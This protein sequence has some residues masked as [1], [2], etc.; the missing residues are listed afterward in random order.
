M[1]PAAHVP[2][3]ERRRRFTGG[4]EAPRSGAAVAQSAAVPLPPP[5]VARSALRSSDV[6]P[7]LTD[8]KIVDL[9]TIVLGP[10]AT[11]TLADLGAQVIKVEP[12][13][14][15]LY[16]AAPPSRHAGMGAPFLAIN[17]GKR[18]ICLDLTSEAGR[19]VLGR[20]ADSADVVIHNML[21]RV[22]EKL[23][24][25]GD[26]LRERRPRLIHCVTPGFGSEGPERD[27]PAYD[28][29]I[30]GRMGLASLMADAGGSPRLVPT[31]LAD[32][33][34]G[35][36]AAIAVLAALHHREV[37]GRGT[38][39]EVP[40][41]E[42]MTGFLLAEHMGGRAFEPELGPA[43]YNRL[44]NPHRRPHAT[45]DG[46]IVLLPYSARHWQSLL[47]L[48][49]DPEW[50]DADWVLDPEQRSRRIEELYALVGRIMPTRSTGE[51]LEI[52]TDRG[53]PAGPVTGLDDLFDDPHL[54]A[55]GFFR[56]VE[57]PSEGS[58]VETRPAIRVGDLPEHPGQPVPRLGEHGRTVLSELGYSEGETIELVAGGAVWIP[59]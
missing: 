26:T 23:G 27:S 51:W 54:R 38:S 29:V 44:L 55:V 33:V 30:Q 28:D 10:Y 16:R 52:L 22:A 57:H 2:L 35:L 41:L 5:S 4:G 37:T 56:Q 17:R 49:D 40:M 15:D 36:H 58:I 45:S 46:H 1:P 11:V 7:L 24:V 20:L 39:I 14:G 47:D 18:S 34:T 42:T 8:V 6:L 31:T 19:Q 21:P 12:P 13:G 25:D 32:K 50:V 9:S 53:I 48:A 3:A 59:D 43:G